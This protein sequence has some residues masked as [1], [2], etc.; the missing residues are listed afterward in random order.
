[1]ART[2]NGIDVC[3]DAVVEDERWHRLDLPELG[4][5]ACFTTLTCFGIA[6]GEYEI[7]LLGC[8]DRR[9]EELNGR[10]RSVFRPTNVLA[11]PSGDKLCDTAAGPTA[12]GDIALAWETCSREAKMAG[13]RFAH[14]VSHL[15]VHG[16]LHLVGC[17]HD[18]DEAAAIMEGLEVEILA[19]LGIANPYWT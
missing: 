17:R 3:V 7:G 16:C 8:D 4:Q 18:D 15:V 2:S 9:M 14:H 6:A 13:C 19:R 10:F 1:M 11:W 12:L 5:L